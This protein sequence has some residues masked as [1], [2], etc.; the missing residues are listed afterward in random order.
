MKKSKFTANHIKEALKRVE[1]GV[2][3]PEISQQ[4]GIS[5]DTFYKWRV[6]FCGMDVTP[7]Q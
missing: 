2:S 1:A 6:N 7:F 3:V 5:S 4:M